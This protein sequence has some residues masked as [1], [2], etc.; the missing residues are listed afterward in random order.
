[1]KIDF[2]K[3]IELLLPT[4]LRRPRLF[5]LL[6]TLISKPLQSIF[7]RFHIWRAKSRYEASVT[8]QVCSLTHA[9]ERTFD[10]VCEIQELDGKPYDFLVSIDRS[11]DLNAI[12]EFIDKHKLAGKS[13]IF[14]LGDVDFVA[15]WLNY[16]NEDI[17]ELYIA[18]WD[19][20]VE[21]DDG[22]N[23]IRIFLGMNAD[24]NS[25]FVR[26]TADRP[27]KSDLFIAVSVFYWVPPNGHVSHGGDGSLSLYIG[28]TTN[29]RQIMLTGELGAIYSF[30]A[31]VHPGSDKFYT[32]KTIGGEELWR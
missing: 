11:T 31:T 28:E 29:E 24:G 5:A 10:C 15:E 32:Y 9:V 23:N 17:I 7:S 27:V 13:Y 2:N 19:F 1:M 26:A 3:L 8:M 14:K 12:R 18:E 20:Y 4:F 22:I 30:S 16:V 21:E 25:W 6:R